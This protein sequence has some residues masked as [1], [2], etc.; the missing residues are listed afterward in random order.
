MGCSGSNIETQATCASE[1]EEM[2]KNAQAA[3]R[4]VGDL[5]KLSV[6]DLAGG[7]TQ[8]Y[9]LN[10]IPKNKND[11]KTATAG[12]PVLMED[13]SKYLGEWANGLKNGRGKQMFVDGTIFEGIWVDGNANGQGKLELTGSGVDGSQPATWTGMVRSNMADGPGVFVYPDKSTVEGTWAKDEKNGYFTETWADGTKFKGLYVDGKKEGMGCMLWPDG[14]CYLG[15][16]KSDA[17]EGWGFY[18]W[19]DGR[20]ARCE[21]DG[22]NKMHGFGDFVWADGRKY[23][24]EYVEGKKEGFGIFYWPDGRIATGFWESSQQHGLTQLS[25]GNSSMTK[26]AVYDKGAREKFVEGRELDSL[27]KESGFDVKRP[28]AEY[29]AWMSKVP[30]ETVPPEELLELYNSFDQSWSG[31]SDTSTPVCNQEND[32]KKEKKAKK[33]KRDKKTDESNAEEIEA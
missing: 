19:G 31:P 27:K 4:G 28:H 17:L 7:I 22:V 9:K 33:E 24:G 3:Q 12:T 5:T 30:T 16:F 21:W 10:N 8:K 20:S 23:V 6:A 13:N 1:Y 14:S 32:K 26:W 25:K 18:Q 15:D 11:A 29:P 2:L